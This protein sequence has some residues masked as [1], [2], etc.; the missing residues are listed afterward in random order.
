MAIFDF[1]KPKWTARKMTE[2]D[3]QRQFWLLRCCTSCAPHLSA[4]HRV[5]VLLVAVALSQAAYGGRSNELAHGV[6]PP[7]TS[8]SST[9]VAIK[10]MEV[11]LDGKR[12][13]I[14]HSTADQASLITGH[15][16]RSQQ[17]A[18]VYWHSTGIRIHAA[19]DSSTA[20]QPKLVHTAEIWLRQETDP[21]QTKWR[22]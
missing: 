11:T 10:G 20:D 17:D 6:A 19:A 4:L 1:L 15:D 5:S 13:E 16:P 12:L 2:D 8:R 14:N 9:H 7:R 21:A 3:R 22:D 18:D